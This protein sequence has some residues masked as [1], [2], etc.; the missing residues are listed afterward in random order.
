MCMLRVK[1]SIV[2]GILL[3]SC[4]VNPTAAK[5]AQCVTP[6]VGT[7]L[8]IFCRMRRRSRWSK[9]LHSGA[10][11]TSPHSLTQQPVFIA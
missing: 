11:R 10:G 6:T 2:F 5:R 9:V 1:L 8:A 7:T 3:A 4:A